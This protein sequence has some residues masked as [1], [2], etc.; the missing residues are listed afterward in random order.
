MNTSD[1]TYKEY[2]FADHKEVYL[3]LEEVF[4]RFDAHYY[5]IGAN[6]RDVQLY[7]AG[8][9]PN[10]GTADID[11]AVMLPSMEVY[12]EIRVHLKTIGFEEAYGKMP[13]RLFYPESNTVIDLLPYGEFAQENTIHFKERNMELSIVGFQEV[14]TSTEIFEHPE[15]ITL[16]VSPAHGIVILKLVSWSEKSTR[17]KDLLDIHALIEGAWEIYQDE[18]YTSDS[19]HADLLEVDPFDIHHTAARIMGRKMQAI[20]DQSVQLKTTIHTALNKKEV[21]GAKT[22][23]QMAVEMDKTVEEIEVIFDAILQGITDEL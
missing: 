2:S 17:T 16:P 20:L 6:A 15:G 12:D 19:P 10:R 4:R 5:L 13:Y 8:K 18:V 21:Q 11:F 9:K 22:A 1:L 7:R 14:G 23:K 3:K